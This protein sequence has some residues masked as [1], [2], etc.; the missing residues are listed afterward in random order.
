MA[1]RAGGQ[2][3]KSACYM[4]SN[5]EKVR[6]KKI[7]ELVDFNRIIGIVSASYFVLNTIGGRRAGKPTVELWK[8]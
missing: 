5:L 4:T 2:C 6:C 3:K 8:I 7:I 1:K